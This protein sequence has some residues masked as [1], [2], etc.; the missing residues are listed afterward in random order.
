MPC[1]HIQF[2]SEWTVFSTADGMML[3]KTMT[4]IFKCSTT[5]NF[6]L[7]DFCNKE[8]KVSILH[9]QPQTVMIKQKA[10]VFFKLINKTN[11]QFI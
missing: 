3:E 5:N 10:N 4:F 2:K 8:S 1:K 9:N 11:Y 7:I 6:N